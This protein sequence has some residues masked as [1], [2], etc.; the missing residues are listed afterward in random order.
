[1]KCKV[2]LDTL[3]KYFVISIFLPF[4]C[5]R[6]LEEFETILQVFAALRYVVSIFTILALLAHRLHKNNKNLFS[7]ICGLFC[8]MLFFSMIA[9]ATFYLT[10][11]LSYLT[12]IGFVLWN[13]SF[14]NKNKKKFIVCYKHLLTFYFTLNFFSQILMPGGFVEGLKGDN[15]VY[16]MG[17][18]N[19]LS[20]YAVFYMLCL[21]I[22][23]KE[24]GDMHK[25][26]LI[27]YFLLLDLF[28][29][30]NESSTAIVAV[31]VI[32]FF[33]V[34]SYFLKRKMHSKA[35][36]F[37]KTVLTVGLISV[38]FFVCSVVLQGESADWLNWMTS[39][40]GKSAT[41]SGRIQIWEVARKYIKEF[42]LWGQGMVVKYDPWG[43]W[44]FVYSA[45]NTFLDL[46]VKY[47][48]FPMVLFCVAILLL[49]LDIIKTRKFIDSERSL[50]VLISFLIVLQFEALGEGQNTWLLMTTIY[51]DIKSSYA[52]VKKIGYKSRIETKIV[53]DNYQ[54]RYCMNE[55]AKG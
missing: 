43:N 32:Q 16:F 52:S 20:M 14:W 19:T 30:V 22:E 44:V 42:P 12:I 23:Y 29:F 4:G 46:G 25:K 13:M 6:A 11:A 34:F 8:V 27:A 49:I 35:N 38:I 9:N 3:G 54:Y 47:G 7:V 55:Y 15:R 21:L 24:I 36:Y 31:G 53:T 28:L 50:I 41:F 1:M 51:L 26:K 17:D 37:L 40:F 18:K 33:Y 48:L 39:F 45:H 5:L 2:N 10:G